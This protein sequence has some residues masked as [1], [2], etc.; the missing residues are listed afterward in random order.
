MQRNIGWSKTGV[1]ESVF[2]LNA[3]NAINSV[4]SSSSSSIS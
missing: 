1:G 3:S 2:E 4:I